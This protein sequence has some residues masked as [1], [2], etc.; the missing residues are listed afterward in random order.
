MSAIDG[1]F[2]MDHFSQTKTILI[3]MAIPR[4]LRL[5]VEVRDIEEEIRRSRCRDRFVLKTR[6]AVRPRD[7]QL[8]IAEEK[9][10]ILHFCGHGLE[11]GDLLLEDNMGTPK[12]VAPSGLA[13]S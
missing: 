3:L 4:G 8:A 6:F 9:P 1:K 11:N 5:D 2:R 13:N 12:P 7:F 10:Y